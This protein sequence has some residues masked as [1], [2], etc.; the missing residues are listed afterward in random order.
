MGDSVLCST[1]RASDGFWRVCEFCEF[2][3]EFVEGS[4]GLCGVLAHGVGPQ[5]ARAPILIG[6]PFGLC[7]GLHTSLL[8]QTSLALLFL[9]SDRLSSSESTY[10]KP[11]LNS[12]HG[13]PAS[14]AFSN[15]SRSM[16]VSAFPIIEQFLYEQP[17][18]LLS[19]SATEDQ[20]EEYN[21]A[22]YKPSVGSWC[23][24]IVMR[25]DR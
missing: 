23:S 25:T 19:V 12:L 13:L 17:F 14:S 20:Q 6:L 4:E 8:Q 21:C 18:H 16:E 22:C 15:S 2:C 9:N 3:C 1:F 24:R 5:R 10:S 11:T 7:V